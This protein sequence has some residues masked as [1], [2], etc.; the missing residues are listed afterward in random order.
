MTYR[1]PRILAMLAALIAL[2]AVAAAP[3]RA[4]RGDWRKLAD[5]FA[6]PWVG[7]QQS[8]GRYPDFTDGRVPHG[9]T[10]GPGT[11]Y[12]DSVLALAV[13][14]RGVRDGNK[15]YIDSALRAFAWVVQPKRHH[16]QYKKPSVFE[17][18]AVAA[19][20]NIVKRQ[21]PGNPIFKRHRR[22]WRSFLLRVR[23]VSTILRIPKTHR[24]SN[25]YL[26]EAVE[27][28]QLR[29]TGLRSRNHRVVLGPGLGR[30]VRI[31]KRM[32]NSGI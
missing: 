5:Q 14:Q 31:Y 24:F 2:A 23:P 16:L 25:H 4:D 15:Q 10:L 20:Y 11:R 13:L 1:S 12:G 8:N 19:G 30:A 27:V 18:M 32:I 21:L 6:Q 28:F 3:A 9:R 17:S 7:L 29:A 26:I 22:A